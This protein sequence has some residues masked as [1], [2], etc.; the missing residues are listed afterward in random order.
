M[1]VSEKTEDRQREIDMMGKVENDRKEIDGEREQ[2]H[3]ENDRG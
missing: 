3:R 1:P 2:R